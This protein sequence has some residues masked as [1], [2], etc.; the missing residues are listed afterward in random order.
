MNNR[1]LKEAGNLDSII[2]ALNNSFKRPIHNSF[3]DIDEGQ[4]MDNKSYENEKYKKFSTLA[5]SNF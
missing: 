3:L 5:S 4:I 1:Q 2:R